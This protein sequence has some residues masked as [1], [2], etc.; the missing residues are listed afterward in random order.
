MFRKLENAGR[1]I[2]AA[3]AG[4]KGSGSFKMAAPVKNV[5]SAVAAPAKKQV[6]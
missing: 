5:K 6:G 3:A 1:I 4:K 2:P